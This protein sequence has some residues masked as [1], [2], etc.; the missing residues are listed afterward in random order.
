M[1][2]FIEAGMRVTQI[3]GSWDGSPHTDRLFELPRLDGAPCLAKVPLKSRMEMLNG[4]N[5][6]DSDLH[7]LGVFI[8]VLDEAD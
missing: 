7:E 5:R 1:H 4:Q 2:K 3:Y 6:V 8:K